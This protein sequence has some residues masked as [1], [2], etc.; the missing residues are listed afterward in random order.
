MI[1]NTLKK[2][3]LRQSISATLAFWS[4]GLLFFQPVVSAQKAP[5][6]RALIVAIGRYPTQ[7][8]WAPLNAANDASLLYRT[9]QRQGFEAEQITLLA[10][11]KATGEQILHSI[12][13][14]LLDP[15]APG[16]VLLLHYS[17]HGTRLPDDNGD[18]L[19]GLDEAL[20]PFD[21]IGEQGGIRDETIGALLGEIRAKIGPT[22]QLIVLFD[23]CHMGSAT[24]AAPMSGA[25]R[26]ATL[27]AAKAKNRVALDQFSLNSAAPDDSPCIAFFATAPAETNCE[28]LAPDGQY[29]GPL[30]YFFCEVLGQATSKPTWRGAFDRLSGAM[31]SSGRCRRQTP[32]AEGNLDAYIWGGTSRS[33]L[34]Y[35]K[36]L[37]ALDAGHVRIDGGWLSGFRPG[38]KVV[39][40]PI[41]TRDT[42]GIQP[43]ATGT[44]TDPSGLLE[45]NVALDRAS[46]QVTPEAAWAMVR[47]HQLP[48]YTIK[49]H[50]LPDFEAQYPN[51]IT[52][53]TRDPLVRRDSLDW[54]VLLTAPNRHLLRVYTAN[55]SVLTETNTDG[56]VGRIMPALY[57]YAKAQFWREVHMDNSLYQAT[58]SADTSTAKAGYDVVQ[59]TVKNTGTKPIYY[60]VIDIDAAHHV[61]VLI[62]SEGHL[63]SE[64]RLDTGKQRTHRVRFDTP[65]QEVLKLVVGP[66]ATDLQ[67]IVQLQDQ[68]RGQV[69]LRG[70]T[71]TAPLFYG[72]QDGGIYTYI[73]NVK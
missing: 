30:T 40:Y 10:D 38:T 59:L 49:W 27:V 35:S 69:S 29:Y 52:E 42:I 36:V 19:D 7:S 16:D 37:A 43:L 32:Q 5:Q 31:R 47:Q 55:G 65:G 8:G 63:P 17:G 33:V 66:A 53:L 1:H 64:Y 70:K 9:L 28:M 34:P 23:A 57:R 48:L 45:C 72:G 14:V 18:E 56:A 3:L 71:E 50:T 73:I 58:I 54:T 6:K 51:I 44:V 68:Q 21:A 26:G 15:A 39:F 46:E 20:V 12:R 61:Q 24:R 25:V 11:E 62:P 67:Q 13:R 4:C 41:D 22:G 2:Y 60:G